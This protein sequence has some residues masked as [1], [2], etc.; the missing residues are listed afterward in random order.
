M[1]GLDGGSWNVFD[2]LFGQGAMPNFQ[3]LL[4]E[5]VRG[6]LESTMPPITPV[7]WTSLMTGVNPGKHGIFAFQ[8]RRPDNSYYPLPQNRLDMKVP[9]VFDYYRD[10]GGLISLNLPMSYPATPMGGFMMTGM[11]TPQRNMGNFEYPDGL[12][13]RFKRSGIDYVIDP[14]VDN[15]DRTDAERMFAGWK[16]E[17]GVF[18]DN[19]RSITHAR[20]RAAHLLLNEEDWSL[21]ICVIVGTDRLQ[22]ILWDDIFRPEE[23]TSSPEVLSYYQTVDDEIGE[24]M[25]GL[26]P[27]DCLM[28]VS[29]HGFVRTHGSFQTNQWL[30]DNGWLKRRQAGRSPLYP[31]KVL[32]N[33]LGITRDRL[34]RFIP[35]RQASRVQMKASHIDWDRSEAFLSGPF[36]IRIN[37]QGRETMGRVPDADFAGKVDAIM[38]GLKGLRDEDGEPLLAE[39]LRG[40]DIYEG[41]SAGEAG[42]II[43]SFR[44]D[45]NFTAYAADLGGKTFNLEISKNGD[46]RVDGIFAAWGGGTA[47]LE[48]EVRFSIQDVLPTV[49]YLN[50][51]ALPNI[52]DGEVQHGILTDDHDKVEDVDWRRFLAAETG[53]DYDS[54]QE[55]EINERLKALGYLSDD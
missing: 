13:D 32:L 44:D 50:Q 45:R 7:A 26:D 3:K 22:H 54:T 27:E 48:E 29:D 19:L 18:V 11:M 9:T 23:A 36:A 16:S 10:S 41:D 5:G 52:F 28:V 17:S 20:M 1:L 35:E 2:H 39:V 31:L 15:P 12:R 43:F 53:I 51:K 40:S 49:M 55:D 25:A 8:K 24:L 37:L 46:H 47:N 34:S 4:K 42:D 21:F 6:T 14:R 30:L 33:K 38:A